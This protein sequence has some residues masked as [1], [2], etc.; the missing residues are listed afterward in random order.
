MELLVSLSTTSVSK[1]VCLYGV[2]FLH[3]LGLGFRVG[4][5]RHPAGSLISL[6][7][8]MF[9]RS[10]SQNCPQNLVKTNGQVGFSCCVTEWL[11]TSLFVIS[12]FN[13]FLPCHVLLDT[14]VKSRFFSF[15]IYFLV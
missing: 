3:F 14:I 9:N 4:A 12:V 10:F 1:E 7:T 5:S 6:H 2:F 8:R 11:G 15:F 13:T